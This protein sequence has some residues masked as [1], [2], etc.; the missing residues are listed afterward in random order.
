MDLPSPPRRILHATGLVLLLCAAALCPVF[1]EDTPVTGGISPG[2]KYEVRRLRIPDG[3][4]KGSYGLHL[5]D[6]RTN[7]SIRELH[8]GGYFSYHDAVAGACAAFWH[9]SGR[10]VAVLNTEKKDSSSLYLFAVDGENTKKIPMPDYALQVLQKFKEGKRGFLEGPQVRGPEWIQNA[11]QFRI[12][13]KVPPPKRTENQP[14]QEYES[15]ISVA[16][17]EQ[18]GRVT[19]ELL[20]ISHPRSTSEY[21]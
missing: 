12:F 20:K 4:L 19:V 11:L 15:L 1:A 2:K 17:Q 3:P 14:G 7:E 10:Y 9:P 5:F 13:F 8:S 16:P 18:N 6:V 21:R